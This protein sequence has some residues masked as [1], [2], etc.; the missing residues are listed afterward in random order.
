MDTAMVCV[1]LWLWVFNGRPGPHPREGSLLKLWVVY[2]L[3][4]EGLLLLLV[5]LLV[6]HLEVGVDD[7]GVLLLLG[8]VLGLGSLG[9]AGGGG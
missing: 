3:R 9:G 4:G 1:S 6:D 2:G 8:A 7:V 5:L